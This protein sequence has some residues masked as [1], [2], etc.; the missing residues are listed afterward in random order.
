MKKEGN[1]AGKVLAEILHIGV[2]HTNIFKY[3]ENIGEQ[4]YWSQTAINQ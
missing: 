3:I 2:N 4:T 1:T